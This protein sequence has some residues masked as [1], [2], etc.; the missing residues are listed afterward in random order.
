MRCLRAYSIRPYGGSS[1]PSIVEDL[2][3]SVAK[4]ANSL[5][6]FIKKCKF[7][8]YELIRSL[9]DKIDTGFMEN[10]NK[11]DT[12]LRETRAMSFINH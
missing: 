2:G 1:I 3:C 7:L 4:P 10:R 5:I 11:I 9:A 6:S 8:C 12:G